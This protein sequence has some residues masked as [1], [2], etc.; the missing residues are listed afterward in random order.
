MKFILNTVLFCLYV[1]SF[2]AQTTITLDNH[3]ED[4]EMVP[5]WSDD[6]VGNINKTAITH[7]VDWVYFYI[8]T[9]N[10]VA[11]DENTLPNSI[12]LVIDFDND[13]ATGSNYLNL[14]LGAEMVVNFPSRSV[15]MFSSS[16]T[17]SGPGINSVGVHVAPVYSAFEFEIAIDR[18][19]VNLNDGALKFLWYEGDTSSSIPQGGEVHVLTDFSYSI[20]PTPL[21]RSENTEIRV[22]FWNVKRELDNTSVYDSYNRI[23]DATNPDIIG[24]SEVE[25]Y[26]P[27][28]VADLLD[29]WLPLENGASWFV[30]KDDW[31]LM[32]ASRFPITSI[33]P[34]INRQMPALINTESVWGV[35]TLFT[36]SHLKCCDGDAQRQ[37][38]ADDYMS[39]LR[40]AI[41]PGG[42]LDLPEGSPIIYGGDLNMVGLSGPINTLET[43]DI[44]NNSLH[45]DDFFPDWD[46]SDLTQIVARLTDRAMDYTW[47]ND[48]GSYMPG[49][50]DYIIIS[51]AVIEVLRAYSL[52]T[53]DLPPARLAQY[54]L[55]LY[56]A[57][58]ASDHFMVVADLAL[59]GGISQTDTDGDGVFD[60]VDN[61]PGLSN[62]DQSDFNFDGL[63]DACSDSDLD[64]LSDEIEIL[65]TITDPLIQDTDGDGLTDGIELSLFITDPLHS[66]T[67]ENGLSD[68]EDLLDSG[69]IGAT[70]SGD[71]NN[72]G[73]I[74]IGDLLLVLSAFGDVCS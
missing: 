65:I 58:D 40:D 74:T 17:S 32:I 13:I 18:S 7:D 19:L 70:C 37:E 29:M 34:T 45:G 30:E 64:G 24:F 27:S 49:K 69:E 9:T 48:S 47:R 43:G 21:E 73:S 10:E 41:E 51:D 14:G 44:Y 46:S 59:V 67:N 25:D 55:E 20:A 54:N 61:C 56:D 15:T 3:F 4:W 39:F 52:Q 60:A 53:S 63:G 26:T 6:G 5:S 57:E 2:S 33:F 71:T 1:S 35:P 31:D 68:A 62:V 28:F 36:C 42:V 72:D 8:R 38:Q 12:R 50:L 11:L 23:L 22:A 66:D 16:G